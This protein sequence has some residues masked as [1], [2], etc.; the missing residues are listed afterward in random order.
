MKKKIL[1]P[2][3]GCAVAVVV[4]LSAY[5]I[6]KGSDSYLNVL[7]QNA[8][9]IGRVNLMA[10]LQ[11]ADLTAQESL[12]LFQRYL[13][14]DNDEQLGINLTKPVYA[15]VSSSDYIGL[16]AAVSDESRLKAYIESLHTEGISTA[17]TS[18]R[19]YSWTTVKG[20]W[21][22]AFND[23][24][25]LMMGPVTASE[26]DQLRL[27]ML[28]LLR[29]ESGKSGVS[30]VLFSKLE[31]SD[32][33]F[34]AVLA[35]EM[36][37]DEARR[38]LYKFG[39]ESKEDALLRLT[40]DTDDN[41]LELEAELLAE[42]PA[43]EDYLK[44]LEKIMQPVSAELTETAHVNNFAWMTAHIDS[45]TILE[46]LRS[47]SAIRTLLVG[48]NFIIDADK[49]IRS[50]GGDLSVEFTNP[51]FLVNLSGDVL[52]DVY[53]TAQMSNTDFLKDASKWG[54]KMIPVQA[55]SPKDFSFSFLSQY[56]YF[57]MY[58]STFY[59]GDC[60][61]LPAEGND[62]LR[63]MR[64]DIKGKRFYATFFAPELLSILT[65]ILSDQGLSFTLPSVLSR[66]ERL[67]IEM[68]N[69][70]ELSLRLIA[71]KD[72]DIARELLNL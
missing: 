38:L 48:L 57:G 4:A 60:Q 67:D 59:M 25:A 1:Y 56:Y 32:E 42:S 20:S 43:V 16:A 61:W 18:Q 45:E 46:A 36:L 27:E 6:F 53:F 8:T 50:V 64:D 11:D 24:K 70:G 22:L 15:F 9:A 17:I 21:L 10:V 13:N 49:I 34:A 28:S 69:M 35:P 33:T 71:P 44:D 14:S 2:I 31:Q 7:P 12:Q 3:V 58:G 39:V 40:L 37:P 65:S 19:G 23:K 72:T 66:F 62:Y 55:I 47:N 29:Q 52:R 5:F 54:N 26:Q 51:S 68:E 30:S 63:R 41:E